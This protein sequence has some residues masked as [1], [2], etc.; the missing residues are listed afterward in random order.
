MR[1]TKTEENDLTKLTKL[2]KGEGECRTELAKV[3]RKS[4]RRPGKYECWC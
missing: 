1:Q 2:R 3:N 4:R